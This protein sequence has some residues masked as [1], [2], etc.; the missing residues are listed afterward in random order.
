[1]VTY[2]PHPHYCYNPKMN[3]TK[4]TIAVLRKFLNICQ[5]SNEIYITSHISPDDDSISSVLSLHY[6]LSHLYPKKKIQVVYSGLKPQK[7]DFLENASKIN[8]SSDISE[9]LPLKVELLIVCDGEAY[10]RFT[11]YSEELR[12][13]VQNSI[14]IDHHQSPKEEKHT[15][16]LVSP[17]SSSTAEMLY[18]LFFS[19][20]DC[21]DLTKQELTKELAEIFMLGIL[22]DSGNFTYLKPNQVGTL[23]VA[24]ELMLAG[25]IDIQEFQGRYN[26]F[27]K[28]VFDLIAIFMNNTTFHQREDGHNF[29]VSFLD[30]ETKKTNEYTDLEIAKASEIYVGYYVRRLEGYKWGFVLTPRGGR[31]CRVSF[32]SLPGSINV[33]RIV[34]E[35][36]IGGGHDR[37]AGG[38]FKGVDYGGEEGLV[39]VEESR[40]RILEWLER[41]TLEVS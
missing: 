25:N 4:P 11:A 32:R 35:M 6:V 30:W 40:G 8:Y 33:R 12:K 1:M 29:Q 7:Y 2:T 38:G 31:D 20:K 14:C 15:L 17:I 27:S 9:I 23:E 18:R 3:Y 10:H 16:S 24:K 39:S 5:K 34:E 41:N 28:R 19:S 37:S 36:G 21:L 26:T 13:R 22:G